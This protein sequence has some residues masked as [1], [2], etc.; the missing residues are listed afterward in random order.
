MVI[1]GSRPTG[2]KLT[3]GVDRQYPIFVM[4]RLDPTRCTHLR[5]PPCDAA[6]STIRF[7]QQGI[8]ERAMQQH[9]GRFGDIRRQKGG[10]IFW[11]V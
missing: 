1:P 4:G 3:V 2:A 6:R 7:S 8:G 10:P 5:R 9:L 11:P